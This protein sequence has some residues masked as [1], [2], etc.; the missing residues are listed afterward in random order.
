MTGLGA[1]MFVAV[2]ALG[3]DGT[4]APSVV[5]AAPPPITVAETIAQ[6]IARA[7][8]AKVDEC[9]PGMERQ[10][11][12]GAGEDRAACEASFG[13]FYGRQ[14]GGI[15]GVLQEGFATFNSEALD[16]CMAAFRAAGCQAP[17]FVAF[18]ACNKVF[19]GSVTNADTCL[20]G[21]ECQSRVCPTAAPNVT[22]TC[23][24]RKVD[25]QACSRDGEC[26][27]GLCRMV[28]FS[29]MC[30]ARPLG[31]NSCGGEGFWLTL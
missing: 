1:L 29:G 14:Y 28:L 7:M 22:R 18:A 4:L 17:S 11:V 23:A 21:F 2:A 31:V 24:P 30:A 13:S 20:S 10:R 3:C 25:G 6:A 9:C 15:N 8:C 5:D 27:S 12:L 19:V 16:P 26:A